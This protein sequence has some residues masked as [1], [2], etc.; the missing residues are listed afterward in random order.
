VRVRFEGEG[1]LSGAREEDV[2]R[3]D[4][5]VYLGFTV[6]VLEPPEHLVRGRDRVKGRG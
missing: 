1:D 3:L 5:P 4:V 6:K 2:S